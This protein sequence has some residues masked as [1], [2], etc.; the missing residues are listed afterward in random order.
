[1]SDDRLGYLVLFLGGLTVAHTL[2]AMATGANVIESV[3]L[4]RAT[5][6]AMFWV[7]T[8]V[9]GVLGLALFRLG[10]QMLGWI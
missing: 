6:P 7:V 3:K 9:E 4:Q 5:K 10:A 8:G 1:L 2:H